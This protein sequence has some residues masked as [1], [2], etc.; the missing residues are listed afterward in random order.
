MGGILTTIMMYVV[1]FFGLILLSNW[2]SQEVKATEENHEYEVYFRAIPNVMN[3][4]V[5]M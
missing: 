4:I 3:Q 2:P 1:I 5:S